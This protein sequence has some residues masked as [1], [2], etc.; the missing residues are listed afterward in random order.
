MPPVYALSE[1]GAA[2]QPPA[3]AARQLA[4]WARLQAGHGA[5]RRGRALHPQAGKL[6]RGMVGRRLA[7]AGDASA[8]GHD[9][10]PGP[11]LTDEQ[12]EGGGRVELGGEFFSTLLDGITGSGK[13]EV[14]LQWIAQRAGRRPPGAGAGAE[15]NLT[16]SWRR[17]FAR[18]PHTPTVLPAQQSGRR[19]ARASLAGRLEG[20]RLAGDWHPAGGVHPLPELGLIV[21]DEEHDGSF[22]QQ[23]GLRYHARDLAVWRAQQ[24]GAGGAGSANTPRWKAWRRWPAAIATP[25]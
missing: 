11:A 19:R 10:E 21:V 24:A 4:L 16:P 7:G 3:R 2:W 13:T 25:G 20:L 17:A 15:I 8:G 23:D 5:G 22:K 6:L 18:F 9:G 14:Y 1:A 12:R